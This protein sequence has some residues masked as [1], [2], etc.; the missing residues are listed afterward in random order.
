[1]Y[2]FTI[3]LRPKRFRSFF[4]VRRRLVMHVWPTLPIASPD[5]L[6]QCSSSRRTWLSEMSS[7]W[8]CLMKLVSS[9]F[10]FGPSP[11]II[12]LREEIQNIYNK[13]LKI[14]AVNRAT[15][16]QFD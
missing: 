2:H 3:F 7:A 14:N 4:R 1:M 9:G 16:Q 5:P 13:D 6:Q 12:G 15:W 11:V 8:E 10:L